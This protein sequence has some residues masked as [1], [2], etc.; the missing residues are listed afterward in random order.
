MASEGP[1]Q[2]SSPSWG[3]VLVRIACGAILLKAGWPKIHEGVSDELVLGTRE[4]FANAPGIVR[5]WGEH[6]VLPHPW[7]F[8]HLIAWGEFLGGLALFLGVLTR[9]AGILV[10]FQFLNFFFVGP[11]QQQMFVLLLAVCGFGCAIS[12]AGRKFGAD[13]FLDERLPRWITW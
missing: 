12:R 13:V 10:G 11:E 1:S 5:G 9:P 7:I 4:A 6:V 2:E 3:L 8:S